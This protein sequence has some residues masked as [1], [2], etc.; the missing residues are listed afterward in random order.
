MVLHLKSKI[1][2]NQWNDLVNYEGNAQGFR[3]ITTLQN[4]D[5]KGGLNVTPFIAGCRDKI[6]KRIA[7]Q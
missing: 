5:V 1:D 3:I 7:H 4:P 6:P 2:S